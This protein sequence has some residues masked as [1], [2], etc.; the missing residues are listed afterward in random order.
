MVI[1]ITA[2]AT[3]DTARKA[4]KLG[5]E[6][7]VIKDA[8]FDVEELKVSVGK[9]LEKNTCARRTFYSSANCASAIRSTILS[10]ARPNAG[11][12]PDDRNGGRDHLDGVDN[13]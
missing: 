13:W 3:V 2:F 7:L 9:V 5:A 11:H 8:G 10:G 1:M 12:L 4:F 6:D